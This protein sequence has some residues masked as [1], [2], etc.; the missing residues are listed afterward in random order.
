MK[1]ERYMVTATLTNGDQTRGY[2]TFVGNKLKFYDE[3]G[4]HRNVHIDTIEPVALPVMNIEAASPDTRRT[5]CPSCFC[6][7]SNYYLRHEYCWS[8]GQLIDWSG[9]NGL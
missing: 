1:K 2:V 7:V 9:V 8:C 5:V 3:S 6:S 4:R